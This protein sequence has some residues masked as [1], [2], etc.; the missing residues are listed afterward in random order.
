MDISNYLKNDQFY[1]N[2]Y[3]KKK[4][5]LKN[6]GATCYINTLIQCFVS[7]PYF[8]RFILSS[9][10]NNRLKY[11]IDS[12]SDNENENKNEN[13]NENI[14]MITEMRSLINSL[15]IQEN[16]LIP[17]RFLK[18]LK[19]KFEYLN[20]NQQNDIHEILML[21]LNQMNEEI[22]MINVSNYFDNNELNKDIMGIKDN[23][24]RIENKCYKEWYNIHNR[25][26]SELIELF[27]GQ[28]ISQ[29]VCGNCGYIHHNH[30]AFNVLNLELPEIE[31]KKINIYDCINKHTSIEK[32]KINEWKCDKCD[33]KESSE[34]IIKYWNFP[35]NLIICLKRFYYS[36]KH[37]TM[38]KNNKFIDIPFEL[39]LSDYALSKKSNK[40]YN[41]R[42]AG[43]HF[44]NSYGGHY[45]SIVR[46]NK[47]NFD[48]WY[49]IDD[50]NINLYNKKNINFNQA[51][52]LFYSI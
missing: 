30:E 8:V 7:L 42:S 37:N 3:L 1:N 45:S 44:G 31:N 11:E 23:Y 38:I 5:G 20:I 24:S 9:S 50:L 34:K 29:I 18:T 51:Y 35:P 39:D 28:S 27:Y 10:Y 12:D 46:K 4:S 40:K 16:S 15:C 2:L 19:M 49:I 52:I 13:E 14:Y 48:E 6:I 22:K 47:D 41:L 32:L 33:K 26:Y 21:I 25:E 43:L 36:Q 17:L